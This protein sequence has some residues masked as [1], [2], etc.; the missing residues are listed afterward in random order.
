MDILKYY[1]T[2]KQLISL[3]PISQTKM[4]PDI[5]CAAPERPSRKP[6]SLLTNK[7]APRGND[8]RGQGCAGR[9]P[10][11]GDAMGRSTLRSR[12]TGLALFRASR[13]PHLFLFLIR[14]YTL[15]TPGAENPW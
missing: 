7:K 13:N 3:H 10:P 1:G 2:P 5:R 15:L 12:C 4:A 14:F 6:A 8:R 9:K 11:P